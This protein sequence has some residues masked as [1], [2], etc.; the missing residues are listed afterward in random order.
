MQ[1]KFGVE[2]DTIFSPVLQLRSI[3]RSS[4]LTVA[5]LLKWQGPGSMFSSSNSKQ[6]CISCV[7]EGSSVAGA[8][9]SYSYPRTP[10][11]K[12]HSIWGCDHFCQ[13]AWVQILAHPLSVLWPFTKSCCISVLLSVKW[14]LK[15]LLHRVLLRLKLLYRKFL[16]QCLIYCKYPVCY[17]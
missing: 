2:L 15:H 12:S 6:S 14:G 7:T 3:D 1:V 4:L 16:E 11:V 13:T 8:V 10:R 5:W 9:L 17:V